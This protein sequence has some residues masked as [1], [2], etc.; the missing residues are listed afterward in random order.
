MS[1]EELAWEKRYS[2]SYE[3]NSFEESDEEQGTQNKASE[4]TT[5]RLVDDDVNE[6]ENQLNL[7][8][9]VLDEDEMR[10]VRERGNQRYIR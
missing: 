5:P 6:N 2:K 7:G 3:T 9:I 10:R 8:K 4:P 1:K